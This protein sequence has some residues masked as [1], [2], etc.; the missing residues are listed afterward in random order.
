MSSKNQD[1]TK[2][3]KSNKQSSTIKMLIPTFIS[4]LS[5]AFG[6]TGLLK[7]LEEE[8]EKTFIYLFLAIV[9]D[10]F[11]GHMARLLNVC[12]KTGVSLDSICDFVNFAVTPNLISY[13]WKMKTIGNLGW[14]SVLFTICSSAFRLAEY[15]A[16]HSSQEIEKK[17]KI[18]FFEGTPCTICAMLILIPLI[19]N[20]EYG[21]IINPYYL[22]VYHIF[23][24]LLTVSKIPTLSL[25]EGNLKWYF[26]F[27]ALILYLFVKF[28]VFKFILYTCIFYYISIPITYIIDKVYNN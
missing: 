20:N 9:C 19:I 1:K 14:V 28:N 6:L 15:S 7:G 11:D 5:I 13:S 2:Y 27:L 12:T 18:L 25:K 22:V 23:I 26:G 21:I 10:F 17:K 3:S 16:E 24:G 4:L 8:Y